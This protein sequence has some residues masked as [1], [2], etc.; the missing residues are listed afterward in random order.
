MNST[1][2]TAQCFRPAICYCLSAKIASARHRDTPIRRIPLADIKANAVAD[3]RSMIEAD[4]GY[5]IDNMGRASPCTVL[6]VPNSS[7]P[8]S[9]TI[10]F[11]L[12]SA[13]CG[14]SLRSSWRAKMSARRG[15]ALLHDL[16]LELQHL[17]SQLGVLGLEHK[18]IESAVMIDRL[19]G[20][21]LKLQAEPAVKRV[22]R[23]LRVAQVPAGTC[24]T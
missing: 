21:G 17:W 5:Q 15:V 23:N 22:G 19:E 3:G 14:P 10:I 16:A 24:A 7:S 12:F 9:R 2:V 11:L 13:T 20:I 4:L 8:L 18:G 1:S 6:R